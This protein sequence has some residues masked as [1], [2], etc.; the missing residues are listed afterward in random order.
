MLLDTGFEIHTVTVL[1]PKQ[2]SSNQQTAEKVVKSDLVVNCRKPRLGERGAEEGGE[3]ALVSQR[4]REILVE[5]LSHAAGQT[6]ERLWAI[7]LKRLLTRG[8]MAEHRFEEI[9]GEVAS[10]SEAGRWFLKEQYELASEDDTR[11][12]EHA[13]GALVRFARLRVAGVPASF[14]ADIVLRTPALAE[15]PVDEA[16]I[17][18]H[19]RVTLI[20]DR[21]D[22]AKFELGGRLR[23][24]SSTTALLL[25]DPLAQGPWCRDI[26]QAQPRRVPRRVPC[27]LQGRRQVAL[28]SARRGGGRVIAEGAPVGPWRRIRQFVAFLVGEGTFPRERTPDAKT[29]VAWL[30]HCAAFGLPAEGVALFE[31]AVLLLSSRSS[32]RMTAM[33]PRLL[34]A[35]RRRA[36]KQRWTMKL[37]S[38]LRK[39]GLTNE[40]D[41]AH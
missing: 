33:T 1:D 10:P 29:L 18:R 20:K 19:I 21:K 41:E 31:K 12:E 16:R 13:G 3:A 36:G 5:S 26:A 4:V 40:S 11:N 27:S 2:K 23:G 7:V 39:K 38:R 24:S 6:R 34:R 37:T 35:V 22:A 14:S 8:L 9:L 25:P 28:P 15:V 17:E 32:R 30:K